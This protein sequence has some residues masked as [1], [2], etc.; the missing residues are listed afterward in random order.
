MDA[1]VVELDTPVVVLDTPAV[2]LDT[3][4]FVLDTPAVV[5]DTPVFELDTPVAVSDTQD[6]FLVDV[7]LGF[8]FLMSAQSE[9]DC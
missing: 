2:E 4:V 6:G 1:P 3:L 7:A 8:E 5:F 9:V